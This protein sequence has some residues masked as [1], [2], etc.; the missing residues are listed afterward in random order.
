MA[1]ECTRHCVADYLQSSARA[2]ALPNATPPSLRDLLLPD[3][4]DV[5]ALVRRLRA[6]RANPDYWREAVRHFSR[7]LRSYT[8]DDMARDIVT[9]IEPEVESMALVS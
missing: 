2:P 6:W 3:P 9:A 7:Q 4:E 1:W 8:W 5:D